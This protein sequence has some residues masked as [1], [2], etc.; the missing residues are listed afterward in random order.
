M[1]YDNERHSNHLGLI[2]V[3]VLAAS[4]RARSGVGGLASVLLLSGLAIL[5]VGIVL[6]LKEIG[7]DPGGGVLACG[8]CVMLAGLFF[9]FF[10]LVGGAAGGVGRVV[11]E[12]LGLARKPGDD[13]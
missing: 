7:L 5:L 8:V 4:P 11:A 1:S 13:D 3:G 12:D 2:T 9:G 6:H 10:W